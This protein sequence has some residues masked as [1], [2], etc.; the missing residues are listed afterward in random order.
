M[1]Y[2]GVTF[3]Q[4]VLNFYQTLDQEP[5]VPKEVEVL[6]PHRVDQTWRLM[7]QFY[8]RYY[9]DNRARVFLI[10]INPGRHGAGVTGVPFTDPIRLAEVCGIPN[11][12]PPKPELSSRFIYQMIEALGGVEIFYSKVYIT[13]VS[14]Y[15]FTRAGKNL[16]YYDLKEL[17]DTWEPFI[18]KSLRSQITFGAN[19]V[20]FSLGQGKNLKY[21]Q[22]ISQKY[23]LFDEVRPLPHPRWVMQYRLKK[24]PQYIEFY[25]EQLAPW[26]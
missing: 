19:P 21:L 20:A 16:N 6:Y 17:Q 7:Q 11:E 18:V 3:A 13:S 8:H 9:A 15:G 12:F 24:L 26:W 23:Q 5:K 22:H 4:Q 14:P 25:Q 10:G 1:L 2:L